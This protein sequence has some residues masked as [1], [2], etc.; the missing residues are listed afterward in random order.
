MKNKIKKTKPK[1]KSEERR[2][3]IQKPPVGLPKK[4]T[5]TPD[6]FQ[7]QI[8]MSFDRGLKEG[9]KACGGCL[10]CYGKG[11]S[12][13]LKEKGTDNFRVLLCKCDRGDQLKKH[14]PNEYG[15]MVGVA[16]DK[17]NVQL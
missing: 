4:F 7:E 11:Y 5:M 9:I 14:F 15:Q 12:T 16:I 6:E 10:I 8:R 3:A 17:K 2:L 1:S 13:Q